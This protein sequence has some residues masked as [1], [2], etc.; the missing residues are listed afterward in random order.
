MIPKIIHQIYFNLYDTKLEEQEFFYRS[1]LN[2]S[3]QKGFKYMLWNEQ[4]S[5]ELIKNEYNTYLKFYKDLRY[6]IQRNDFIRF[7]I[8]HK[9]GGFYIDLDMIILQP[10]DSLI[11]NTKVFHN[12]RYVKPNFSFIEND[13]MG[14]IKGHELWKHVMKYCV[15][16]YNEKKQID[17][18]NTWKGRFV[19]QTTGP[20]FLARFIKKVF[21]KYKPLKLV[22]TKWSNGNK[23]N[24][25]IED[26]KLNTWVNKD[27]HDNWKK[28]I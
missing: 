25:Y 20:K 17:I 19:L 1:H 3:N 8:L 26:Y 23:E 6:D 7:C 18:Y 24:Y 16:N 15:I 5:L 10:L 27:K 4:T 11:N 22:Y 14:V 21:P 13:F 2:C 12:I 9:Y 28:V